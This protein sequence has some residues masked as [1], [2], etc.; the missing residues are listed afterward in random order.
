MTE[1]DQRRSKLAAQLTPHGADALLVS[2]LPNVRYLT[3]FTGSHGLLL[4]QASGQATFLTDPRYRLQAAAEVNCAVKVSTGPI[5]AQVTAL[6]S[7]KKIR[8]L[9]FERTRLAYES[10]EFLK[11]NLPIRCSLQPLSGLA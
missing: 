9:G 5:L 11:S 8:R 1:F 2:F 7:R 4:L 10:Y 6:A 3:G